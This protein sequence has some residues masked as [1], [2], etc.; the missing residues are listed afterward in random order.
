VRALCRD[1]H[2]PI[3]GSRIVAHVFAEL[4]GHG[5]VSNDRQFGNFATSAA[6]RRHFGFLHGDIVAMRITYF[7][8]CGQI[9]LFE[10]RQI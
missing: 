6:I 1:G 2:F 5:L 9:A 8:E 3:E 4:R 7:L 10:H